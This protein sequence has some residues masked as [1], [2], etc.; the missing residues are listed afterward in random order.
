[1]TKFFALVLVLVL[2]AFACNSFT[3]ATAQIPSASGGTTHMDCDSIIMVLAGSDA[4]KKC[5]EVNAAGAQYQ[6]AASATKGFFETFSQAFDKLANG[7]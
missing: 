7:R 4:Q 2:A 1:M 5:R 3:A 6:V